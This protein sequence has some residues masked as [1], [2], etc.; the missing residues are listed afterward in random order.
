MTQRLTGMS[1]F[2]SYIHY[3]DSSRHTYIRYQYIGGNNVSRPSPPETTVASFSSQS[4]LSLPLASTTP[5][6]STVNFY[7][8]SGFSSLVDAGVCSGDVQDDVVNKCPYPILF[9]SPL[10][11]GHTYVK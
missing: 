11:D 1:A 5:S 8:E 7:G 3:V 6:Y 10:P 2:V 9:S 4:P